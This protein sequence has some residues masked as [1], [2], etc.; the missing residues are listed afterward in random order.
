MAVSSF[1]YYVKKYW[2]AN[3]SHDPGNC[4]VWKKKKYVNSESKSDSEKSDVKSEQG[5]W[6]LG[7]IYVSYVF[8][9]YSCI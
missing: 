9:F 2:I 5:S 1:M 4:I 8:S 7:P 6:I 3:L